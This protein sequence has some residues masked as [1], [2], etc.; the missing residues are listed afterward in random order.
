MIKARGDNIQ[1]KQV[2]KRKKQSIIWSNHTSFC[3]TRQDAGRYHCMNVIIRFCR[4]WPLCMKSQRRHVVITVNRTCK[5]TY[6]NSNIFSVQNLS[7]SNAGVVPALP[8][9]LRSDHLFPRYKAV[10]KYWLLT[11]LTLS[12]CGFP[13]QLR[14]SH[15]WLH[16][17]A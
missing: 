11:K 9:S 4:S 8:S 3:R 12:Q 6:K 13:R 2:T 1:R 16:D 7:L 10:S 5:T 14:V 15:A 17:N